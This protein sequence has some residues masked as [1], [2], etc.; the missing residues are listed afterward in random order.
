VA[1]RPSSSTDK[2]PNADDKSIPDVVKDLWELVVSYGKQ[3]TVDPLKRFGRFV[4]YG[5]PA[6]FCL[7][8][9]MILILIGV[10]RVLQT[11]TDNHLA[12]H[13]SWVP[14]LVTLAVAGLLAGLAAFAII[15]KPKDQRTRS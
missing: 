10:L 12:G 8:I 14:Y 11:E 6:M 15:R 3:E 7:G 13:L 1:A 4:A 9:G 5:V 2:A